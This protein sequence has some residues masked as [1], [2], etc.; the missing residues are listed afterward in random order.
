MK[1]TIPDLD[2]GDGQCPTCGTSAS[3]AFINEERTL[4]EVSCP[5][6]GKVEMSRDEFDRA[7]TELVAPE[8]RIN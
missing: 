8:E 6:C 5:N 2:R 1:A 3:W 7:E 4:V